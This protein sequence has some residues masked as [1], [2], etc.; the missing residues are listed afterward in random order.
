MARRSAALA[1]LALLLVC[2][3]GATEALASAGGGSSGFGGGGG[4][5]GGG[6]SGGG[7]SG[8]GGGGFFGVLVMVLIFGGIGLVLA[9]STWRLRRRRRERI[10][11]VR[12]ASA[13]AAEDDPAFA[14]ERVETEARELF[15]AAQQAWDARDIAT[16]ERLVGTDL[17]VEWKRRLDDFAAKGWHNRVEVNGVPEVSYMGLVNRTEDTEDHV[18][19]EIQA[20]LD[21]YVIDADGKRIAKTGAG[22]AATQLHEYWTLAKRD[23]RWI[24]A[25]IEQASEGLHHLDAEIVA[26]PWSD[27]R[28]AD[29]ALVETAVADKLPEGFTPADVADLNF[30]GD[31]RAAALDLSVADPRFAPDVLEA[32]AR[33][34][35]EAWAEA[36][37][38][39]DAALEAVASPGA[40]QELL[41]PGDPSEKT[42]LVV[43]GP[44]VRRI[45]VEALD[46]AAE[47]STMRIAVELGGRRYVE[48]RDTAAVLRGSRGAASTFTEHWTLALDGPDTAPW[49]VV[50]A[51]LGRPAEA[52]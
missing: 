36:V 30:D 41:H 25:S 17:L 47:P 42:R 35:V 50:D 19:V 1:I 11:R 7:G 12:L 14:A 33:R 4:G 10:A 9:V 37:D 28:V 44:R 26:S 45:H 16:I 49:R 31:A 43:R 32:A 27:S 3:T 15:V 22:G 13:E 40:V 39:D 29:E 38:G 21:D 23:G 2:L 18:T 46:A 52:V 20:K 6:F 8:S 34:A 48:D 51:G 24:V 5:G